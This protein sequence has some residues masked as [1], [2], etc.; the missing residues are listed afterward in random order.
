MSVRRVGVDLLAPLLPWSDSARRMSPTFLVVGTKRGGTT[1]TYHWIVRH[2][3]IAPCRALKG[4]HYFDV[5]YGRGPGWFR[6]KFEPL[7]SGFQITGEASPYYMFHPL[8][9]ARIARALPDVKLIL[10]LRDPVA[11]LWSHYQYEVARGHEHLS[12]TEA[13]AAEPSRL[14]GE[15]QRMQADPAYESFSYRHHSYLSRGHYAEQLE[16]LYEFFAAEQVLILQS[17]RLFADPNLELTKVWEFLDV[18]PVRLAGLTA[19]KQGRYSAMPE[20]QVEQLREYY[21]PHNRL[22]YALP[23]IDFTWSAN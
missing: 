19:M 16:R 18:P 3:S 14:R 4:T 23:G 22:L 7:S 5:N 8:A 20:E 12:V 13:V 17:E 11:R 6:S 21:R 1:S 9:P 15:V 2:P 10:V